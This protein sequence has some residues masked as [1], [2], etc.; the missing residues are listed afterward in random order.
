MAGDGLGMSRVIRREKRSDL[1][2]AYAKV[3]RLK[4]AIYVLAGVFGM[5]ISLLIVGM[6]WQGS[7]LPVLVAGYVAVLLLLVQQFSKIR[8]SLSVAEENACEVENACGNGCVP[9]SSCGDR[10][11][12]E[13]QIRAALFDA[14]RL[15]EALRAVPKFGLAFF[16]SWPAAVSFAA[17]NEPRTSYL[18][19]AIFLWTALIGLVIVKY[20]AGK[21]A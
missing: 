2:A 5:G 9:G 13:L 10:L 12:A 21:I 19:A 17:L 4:L 6:L 11:D 1:I 18:L 16:A 14:R 3:W 20:R 7:W 15:T 8:R